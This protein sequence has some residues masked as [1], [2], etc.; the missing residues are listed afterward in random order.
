METSKSGSRTLS[1]FVF[2]NWKRSYQ[3][4]W[5]MQVQ[6][7]ISWFR[8][9]VEKLQQGY[10]VVLMDFSE[11]Y[12]CVEQDDI[13]SAHWNKNQSSV[14]TAAFQVSG[15]TESYALITHK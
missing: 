1:L 2:L 10:A 4:S 5:N 3:L 14:F 12:T 7:D 15:Q 6:A 13:Q 8:K 9:K 11:D